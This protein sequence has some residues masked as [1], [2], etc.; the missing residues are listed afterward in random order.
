MILQT[1][2]A[3]SIMYFKQHTP[4]PAYI[5]VCTY[6]PPITTRSY[7]FALMVVVALKAR[8]EFAKNNAKMAVVTVRAEDDVANRG[9]FFILSPRK[10]RTTLC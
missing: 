3:Q 1:T 4:M 7:V 2:L 8:T 10:G 5:Y 6:V 9:Y